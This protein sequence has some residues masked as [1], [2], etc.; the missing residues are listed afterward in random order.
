MGLFLKQIFVQ[1]YTKQNLRRCIIN[2]IVLSVQPFSVVEEPSFHQMINCASNQEAEV[3]RSHSTV[4]LDCEKMHAFASNW[5]KTELMV[6][7]NT[8]TS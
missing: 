4:K 8:F 6:V 2:W 1:P 7:I 3:I 5:V